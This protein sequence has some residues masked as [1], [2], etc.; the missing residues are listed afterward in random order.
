MIEACTHILPLLYPHSFLP[1]L[2]WWWLNV[3]WHQTACGD[4]WCLVQVTITVPKS[5]SR[6]LVCPSLT[7]TPR[8][9]ALRSTTTVTMVTCSCEC[10]G[11]T[12]APRSNIQQTTFW[13][14]SLSFLK[15]NCFKPLCMC[16][17]LGFWWF[18]LVLHAVT[19]CLGT[20]GH[21]AKHAFLCV[22]CCCTL[23]IHY[24][25]LPNQSRYCR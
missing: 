18:N 21:W 23:V 7:H 15:K 14:R 10:T 12:N 20:L 25:P 6:T 1:A 17:W 9:S 19:K 24:V 3:L 8:S 13:I 11:E 2:T 5:M 22:C 16:I 4:D